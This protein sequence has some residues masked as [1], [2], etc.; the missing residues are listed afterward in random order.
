M[1]NGYSEQSLYK[2]YVN[3]FRRAEFDSNMKVHLA[4]HTLGYK[5]EVLGYVMFFFHA[6]HRTNSLIVILVLIPVRPV[7]WAGRK[8]KHTVIPTAPPFQKRFTSCHCSHIWNIL[9]S[10]L[11]RPFL[12]V[13]DTRSMSSMTQYGDTYM[14]LKHFSNSCAQWR[15]T[16]LLVLRV[17]KISVEQQN[18]GR[19]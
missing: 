12:A 7:D 10:G 13:M 14:Y 4:H 2:L 8:A 16:L 1:T 19:W 5:Q 9:T 15:K 6:L 11:S 18:I 17:G 3:A